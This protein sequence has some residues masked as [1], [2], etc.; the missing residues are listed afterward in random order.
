M[1]QGS[2]ASKS[3]NFADFRERETALIPQYITACLGSGTGMGLGRGAGARSGEGA[4]T[5]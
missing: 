2:L 3:G 1:E 4:S 5:E